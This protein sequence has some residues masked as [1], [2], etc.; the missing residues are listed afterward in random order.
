[1]KK[2]TIILLMGIM[3]TTSVLIKGKDFSLSWKKVES[4]E[5]KDLPSSALQESEKLSKEE[6]KKNLEGDLVLA[7][8]HRAKNL[9][10]VDCDSCKNL[11][12]EG[13]Q[14]LLTLKSPQIRSIMKAMMVN[15]YLELYDSI[16]QEVV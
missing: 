15:L 11:L 14:I 10:L 4:L 9:L 12:V 7:W 5:N 2:T 6:K 8:F 1:M 13:E 16:H 3:A